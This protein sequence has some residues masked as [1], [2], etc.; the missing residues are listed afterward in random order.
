MKKILI[1]DDDEFFHHIFHVVFRDKYFIDSATSA[2]KV[3]E[4]IFN[5]EYDLIIV[6]ISLDK[7]DVG[8]IIIKE[9]RK[10]DAFENTPI[11][12]CTAHSTH[13]KKR[14]TLEAGADYFLT[15][16]VDSRKLKLIVEFFLENKRDKSKLR[17]YEKENDLRDRIT[18]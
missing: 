15:K 9:M 12:C 8:G 5:V 2:E 7:K 14:E 3:Y 6:D 17:E 1:I 16:P 10:L 13:V 4:Y 11:I 18:G